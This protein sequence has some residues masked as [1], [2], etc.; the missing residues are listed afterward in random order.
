MILLKEKLAEREEMVYALG[1]ARASLSRA[2]CKSTGERSRSFLV[3][4][5]HLW[6]VQA[7][8]ERALGRKIL[9]E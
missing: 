2:C 5:S 6:Q 3:K 1:R 4:L 9:I 8:F 7:V